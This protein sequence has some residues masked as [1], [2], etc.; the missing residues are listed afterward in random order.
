MELP[1]L[2]LYAGSWAAMTAAIWALFQR[3]ETV[4]KPEVKTAIS[5][6]LRN[7]NPATAFENWPATFAAVFDRIF[8]ERHLSWRCFL[9]SCVASFVAVVIVTLIWAAIH[10]DQFNA[11]V[12]QG[13]YKY[14]AP[15]LSVFFVAG[16]LN[17]I[18]DYLS[19]LETRYIIRWVS[20]THSVVRILAFLAFDLVVTAAIFLGTYF[21]AGAFIITIKFGEPLGSFVLAFIQ[22]VPRYMLPLTTWSPG[23]AT[24]AIWFYSTFFTSVWVWLYASSG[25]VVKLG[26]YLGIG[27]KALKTVVDIDNKPLR[28]MGFVAMLLVTLVYVVAAPFLL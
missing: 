14:Y 7:L 3:A 27:I 15:F 26:E 24:P 21:A 22:M 2:L 16:I 19:L 6:W 8:G 13:K 25:L 28:S 23:S 17:L 11:F 9:R 1:P 4:L 5:Q 12:Q 18:P 20:Q 10:P